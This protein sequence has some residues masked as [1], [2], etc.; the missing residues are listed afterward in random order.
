MTKNLREEN[1]FHQS[2]FMQ[3]KNQDLRCCSSKNYA[4]P[5][6]VLDELVQIVHCKNI[7]FFPV[8]YNVD[9]PWFESQ[10]IQ[11]IL[12]E[13][14]SKLSFS[15]HPS[16]E[17]LVGIDSRFKELKKFLSP[18]SDDVRMVGI[19]GMGGIGKTTIARVAY[20]MFSD[21]FEGSSF[22]AN[23]R[24][25]SER[26]GQVSVQKLLLSEILKMKIDDINVYND[27]DGIRMIRSRLG[28][29]KVLIVIDDVN[30]LEQ[31][32]KLAGKHDWFGK[33]SRIIITSRDKG[34][35]K[36][37]GVER[38]YEAEKLN[39]DE[40]L[41]LFISK[42]F[43]KHQP[44][45]SFKELSKR[46]VQYASGLPL[47]LKVLGSLFCGKEV[48]VWKDALQRLKRDS[49]KEILDV[50]QIGFDG[51]EES[52][53]KIFLDIACFFNGENRDYVTRIL[54]SCDFSPIVGIDVLIDK[55]LINILC[56]DKLRMH[57]LLQQ[58]GQQI[59]KR[60]C[61]EEP[62]KRSR[63]WMEA[64]IRHVL[65]EN[66]GTKVVEG[67]ILNFSEEKINCCP[68]AFS[69]M[70]NL[71]LLKIR[72][73][74]L[75]KGL[76]Y[77]PNNLRLLDWE[78][79][80]LE[81]L[82]PNL[83]LDKIIELKMD[84]SH[85]QQLQ[86]GITPFNNLE[87]ISFEECEYVIKTPDFT[88]AP[89]LKKVILERCTMLREIHPSLLVHKK[90]TYLNM[91]SC[92]SLITLPNQIHMES[93]EKLDLSFCG[94]LE[95]FPEIVGSMDCLSYLSLDVT[96]IKV[97]PMSIELLSGLEYFSL[98]WCKNLVSL[99][100]TINGLK[101]LENFYLFGCSKLDNLPETLGQV[102]KLS[103]LH[104]GGTAIRRPMEYIFLM[105]NLAW[106]D[107]DGCKRP[108]FRLPTLSGLCTSLTRLNLVDCNMEEG[109]IPN[110][111]FDS[112]PS[113]GE[114]KLSKNNF[115][116]LPES[117][118]HLS[119][120]ELLLLN[121]CKRLRSLP[122]LPSNLISINVDDCV[123]LETTSNALRL[124]YSTL[125]EFSCLN[126]L[127]L[128]CCNNQ[129]SSMPR[130]FLKAMSKPRNRDWIPSPPINEFEMVI[131]GSEIPEW[132]Q[133]Q[134]ETS[135]IK[136]ERPLDS[137]D[138]EMVGYAVCCVFYVHEHQPIPSK[139]YY[140][141]THEIGCR[142]TNIPSFYEPA[143]RFECN[144]GNA[145]SDHLWLL[146]ICAGEVNRRFGKLSFAPCGPRSE[147]KKCGNQDFVEL[148]FEPRGPGSEV[149]K[150]G[151]HPVYKK[152]L[153]KLHDDFLGSTADVDCDG[154]ED[155]DE[156][157]FS[158]D[159]ELPEP[160][161]LKSHKI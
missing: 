27:F 84:K 11:D 147:V 32:E 145:V 159:D 153:K 154:A 51:L 102:E 81:S 9:P 118:N 31:L 46:V 75:P 40:A 68:K 99:P 12:K 122:E 114:L 131:P 126:C 71:R 22:L 57:D 37:H 94:K 5:R 148:S 55:S 41:Q 28:C 15:K 59:V 107:L 19:C 78:G 47:A 83:Q 132:F 112:F 155:E 14:S 158:A 97:L 79:Y 137:C 92:A 39:D 121:G 33:G 152:E 119:K 36:S 89:N 26:S 25:I 104:V 17:G 128:I 60:E 49:K 136:I 111:F 23:V 120:L 35:L 65:T 53:K 67:I 96:A 7:K 38:V 76:D 21:E 123:A 56:D 85:V 52:E 103:T 108:T 20:E 73:V 61:S 101:S 13:I 115:V 160:K 95:K 138:N 143:I 106:L 140:M 100:I 151:I 133:H 2:S 144:L 91:I 18:E 6:G 80:P 156:I 157:Y 90:I 127:K 50:L 4:L 141:P 117:I 149:K 105:K 161:R 43:K 44:S 130:E 88:F 86:Q 150:C 63:L 116:S 48:H 135:S 72:N 109:D 69:K 146:Y 34:L 62:G 139:G 1:R 66:T 129:A 42:A 113:L 110:D 77:L 125:S 98:I 142:L 82:P 134:S 3:L 87:S 24:D 29:K 54:E 124:C 16:V 8:F 45:E 70:I 58:M 64:D 10:F 93:L 74:Q 30:N